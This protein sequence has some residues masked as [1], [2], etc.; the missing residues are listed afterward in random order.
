MNLHNY[1][2]KIQKFCLANKIDF[3]IAWVNRTQNQELHKKLFNELEKVNV[4]N[5]YI[6]GLQQ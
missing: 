6:R 3:A 4:N 2:E 5:T 1:A